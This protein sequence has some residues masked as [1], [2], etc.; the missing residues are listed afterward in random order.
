MVDPLPPFL[1]GKSSLEEGVSLLDDQPLLSI[2]T[3]TKPKEE[4]TKQEPCGYA[5]SPEDV[6]LRNV[7]REK[8]MDKAQNVISGIIEEM[9]EQSDLLDPPF[10]STSKSSS[11][12]LV[13]SFVHPLAS[14]SGATLQTSL[15]SSFSSR[16]IAKEDPEELPPA[17]AHLENSKKILQDESLFKSKSVT[18]G[19]HLEGINSFPSEE[20]PLP[21]GVHDDR[22]QILSLCREEIAIENG[23]MKLSE[24]PLHR[25]TLRSRRS[26]RCGTCDKVIVKPTLNSLEFQRQHCACYFIPVFSVAKWERTSAGTDEAM[27]LQLR[28]TNLREASVTV[29]LKSLQIEQHLQVPDLVKTQILKVPWIKYQLQRNSAIKSSASSDDGTLEGSPS[30]RTQ[31]V[32]ADNALIRVY[33]SATDWS[34]HSHL[35]LSFEC[36]FDC[37]EYSSVFPVQILL[38][39]QSQPETASSFSKRPSSAFSSLT[40][41]KGLFDPDGDE[42]G[43]VV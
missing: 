10:S 12:P 39:H 21:P 42:I 28:V 20:D 5:L 19:K 1:K 23:V 34:A 27:E 24:I 35:S 41:L 33:F 14:G 30:T 18:R 15:S 37:G 29:S 13:P 11:K 36:N 38:Q 9:H 7:L 43:Q 4:E 6:A 26:K 31:I 40:T 2:E 25:K 22:Q 17:L 32:D 8:E 3:T 16:L